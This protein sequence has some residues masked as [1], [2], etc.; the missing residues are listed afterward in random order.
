[1]KPPY[2]IKLDISDGGDAYSKYFDKMIELYNQNKD[3]ISEKIDIEEIEENNIK[4]KILLSEDEFFT[5]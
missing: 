2:D 3:D 5:F 4:E 1:M